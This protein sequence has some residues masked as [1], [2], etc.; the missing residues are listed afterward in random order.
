MQI[1]LLYIIIMPIF[2]FY[3]FQKKILPSPAQTFFSI[4]FSKKAKAKPM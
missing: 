1:V 3:R 2:F 4:Y